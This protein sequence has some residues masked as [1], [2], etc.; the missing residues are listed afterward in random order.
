M[1][2]AELEGVKSPLE[3]LTDII[4]EVQSDNPLRGAF[5]YSDN[6]GTRYERLKVKMRDQRDA[7]L[8]QGIYVEPSDVGKD[9]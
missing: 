5:G 6:Y 8:W 3:S 2:H 7:I 9:V 1:S 4:Y